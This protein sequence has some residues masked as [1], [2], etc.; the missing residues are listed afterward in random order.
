MDYD[1]YTGIQLRALRSDPTGRYS[2][3]V[4]D[5]PSK[6]VVIAKWFWRLIRFGETL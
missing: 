2:P 4:D 5:E 6:L 1:P 3:I